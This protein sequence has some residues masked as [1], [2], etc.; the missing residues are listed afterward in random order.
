[1]VTVSQTKVK[2]N[3][4]AT[5]GRHS[6]WERYKVYQ[7]SVSTGGHVAGPRALRSNPRPGHEQ[8]GMVGIPARPASPA[9]T[10]GDRLLDFVVV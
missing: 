2:R 9:F 3:K 7:Q 1:M 6:R 8:P 4:E 10:H 5:F